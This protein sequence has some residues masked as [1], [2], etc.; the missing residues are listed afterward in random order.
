MMSKVSLLRIVIVL[1][2][3]LC[4][5]AIFADFL[6]P[7]PP[8]VQNLDRFY[9]PPTSIHFFDSRGNFSFRPSVCDY[10]LL[11]PLDTIY[12]ERTEVLHPIRF[13]V[14]GYEYRFLGIIPANTHLLGCDAEKVLY[15]LGTDELGRDVL[16]RILAGARTS[17][18]IMLAG[19]L[20]Y[21]II[22]VA[23]GALA[24]LVGGWLDLVL[25]RFSEFVLALPALYLILALRA[26]LPLQ[27]PFWQT[28]LLVVGTIAAVTWPPMARGVRGLILQLH[29]AGY[30]EA[31]RSLGSP[32]WRIF[33]RHMLPAFIP[34]VLTQSAVAAPV[35]IL[36]EIVLSFLNVGMTEGS[37]SWGSMLRNLT[38]PRV[39]TDFWWNLAPLGCVFAA[40]LCLNVI[41]SRLRLR[42]QP[43]VVL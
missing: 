9:A 35:F 42:E 3:A 31:A 38:D 7:N 37:G 19:I 5:A 26:V 39:L 23:I 12:A 28:I 17:L 21:T 16:A 40:L 13:L 41:S 25:M 36:G 27:M 10:E 8:E 24:G 18:T 11:D 4:L 15:L 34:F 2:V 32:P 22:G 33:F 29:N 6:S 14:E 43:K 30:V 1:L 20:I